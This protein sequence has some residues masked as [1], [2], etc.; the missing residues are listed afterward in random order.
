MSNTKQRFFYGYFVLFACFLAQVISSGIITYCFSVYVK[1]LTDTFG[2]SRAGLMAGST[3]MNLASGFAAPVVG[4]L[5]NRWGSRFVIALGSLITGSGF[6]LLSLTN[7]TWHFYLFYAVVGIGWATMGIVPT[8]A[9]VSNWFKRRRGFAIGILG[10]GI[11]VGGFLMPLLTSVILIPNFGWRTSY[12]I[13]GLIPAIVM[14]PVSLLVIRER[15]EEMGLLPDNDTNIHVMEK[16]RKNAAPERSL[17]FSEAVRTIPFWLMFIAFL[18]FSFA[19]QSIFQN[20]A[21]HLQ[22]IGFADAIAASAISISG[23][24][25]AFGKFGLGWL[26]DFVSSKYALV[27]GILFQASA[28]FILMNIKPDSPVFLVWTYAILL[29]LGVGSW[30][31]AQ[32]MTTS[33]IFGLGSYGTIFGVINLSSMIGGALGPLLAG[34]IFDANGSYYWAFIAAFGFYAIALPTIMLVRRPKINRDEV[35]AMAERQRV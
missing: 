20:H 25:S 22:Q 6:A 2:W 29:G 14:I 3:V 12:F 28:V 27:L 35:K 9:V 16:V 21:P 1:P 15:P 7:D 30:L 5:I 26:C 24:G 23:I 10:A 4:R 17:T 31:P 8:S 13:T 18:T 33:T 34:M 19:N 11:G 32:S